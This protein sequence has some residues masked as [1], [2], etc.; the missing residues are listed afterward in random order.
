M[1]RS[2]ASVFWV[3]GLAGCALFREAPEVRPD[4]EYGVQLVEADAIHEFHGR[5]SGFYGRLAHRRFNTLATFKDRVLREYFRSEGDFADYY[6]DLADGLRTG[7]FERSTPLGL[8]VVEFL[9]DGP[10][11][12]RVRI[13]IA[14]ENGLPLRWWETEIEREDR[15]ERRRGRWWIVPGKL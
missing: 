14:G 1:R 15:W 2:L 4:T 9:I 3:L 10:G 13:R 11:R 12:A 8:E 5:A 7:H 6:A